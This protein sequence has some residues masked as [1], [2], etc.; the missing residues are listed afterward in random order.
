MNLNSENKYLFLI[1]IYSKELLDIVLFLD[2]IKKKFDLGNINYIIYK[3]KMDN[4][5]FLTFGDYNGTT[6]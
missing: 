2:D 4:I 6:N 1:E 5:E 3:G